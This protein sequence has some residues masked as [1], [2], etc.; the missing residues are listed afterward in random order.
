MPLDIDTIHKEVLELFSEERLRTYHRLINA[1]TDVVS[2]TIFPYL[3]MQQATA[4]LYPSIHLVEICLRNRID[5]ALC[6]YF[7]KHPEKITMAGGAPEYW[8]EWLKFDEDTDKAIE[9][10]I[11]RAHDDLKEKDALPERGDIISRMTFGTWVYILRRITNNPADRYAGREILK[12]VLPNYKSGK[13]KV[14]IDRL[15]AIKDIRN[16][17]FH[18]EPVWTNARVST[19]KQ[20]EGRFITI[21]DDILKAA[22]WISPNI[23]AV[24]TE[25]LKCDQTFTNVLKIQFEQCDMLCNILKKD[26]TKE[27]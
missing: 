17:L 7:H 3:T 2:L 27:K 16:R 18:H 19:L 24:Y 6:T 20:A 11:E 1:P 13:P 25:L 14:A 10:A 9:D 26:L 12:S 8:Y 21:H 5:H 15:F 23:H 22:E 4:L